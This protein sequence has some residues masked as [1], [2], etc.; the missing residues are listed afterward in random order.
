MFRTMRDVGLFLRVRHTAAFCQL[1]AMSSWHLDHRAEVLSGTEH[2]GYSL[3]AT[4]QLQEQIF[5]PTRALTGDVVAAVLVFV[6]AA[7]SAII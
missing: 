1:L 6:C 5:D 2:L 4:R 3:A 7:V